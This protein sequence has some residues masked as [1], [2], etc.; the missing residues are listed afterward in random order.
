MELND[1]EEHLLALI[2][3]LPDYPDTE[4]QKNRIDGDDIPP[5]T[6]PGCRYPKKQIAHLLEDPGFE[7]LPAPQPLHHE[8]P[9]SSPEIPN[10][11]SRF[12]KPPK[13]APLYA[14]PSNVFFQHPFLRTKRFAG[15]IALPLAIAATA[16]GICNTTKINFLKS[17]LTQVQENNKRLFDVVSSHNQEFITLS[18]AIQNLATQMTTILMS[19]PTLLDA[20]L[21]GIEN[22]IR[23]WLRM[24]THAIQAGQHRRLA[25]DYLTSGRIRQLFSSLQSRGLEF[26]CELLLAHHSDL[27]QIEVSLALR[28]VRRTSPSACP[29]GALQ[30]SSSTLQTCFN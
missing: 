28:R 30:H 18:G 13:P 3:V 10:F 7:H 14:H 23:N 22:Q 17:E 6:R 29:H 19:N 2:N 15:V 8:V 9:P 12:V 21:T 25:V 20:R 24:A 1:L 16:M 4:A 27:F 5:P 26:S 11:T